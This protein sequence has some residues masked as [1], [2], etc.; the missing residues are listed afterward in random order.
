MGYQRE[1]EVGRQGREY[2]KQRKV[3]LTPLMQTQVW[4][5]WWEG[6]KKS[7]PQSLDFFSIVVVH[8]KQQWRMREL[9]TRGE[10]G[11][12]RMRWV[13]QEGQVSAKWDQSTG[14]CRRRELPSSCQVGMAG[15]RWRKTCPPNSSP[16]TLVFLLSSVTPGKRSIM[17]LVLSCLPVSP[18]GFWTTRNPHV[19]W[20]HWTVQGRLPP[21]APW[22][23]CNMP[24]VPPAPCRHSK[25]SWRAWMLAMFVLDNL[26]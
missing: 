5:S 2:L 16:V 14:A 25:L 18:Q 17:A 20:S 10:R 13:R 24:T 7:K 4:K 3:T 23:L 1:P 9:K 21:G 6:G 19:V 22:A 12:W 8:T 15:C 11:T 26:N